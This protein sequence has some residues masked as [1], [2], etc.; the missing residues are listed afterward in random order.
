[1]SV[2][3]NGAQLTFDSPLDNKRGLSH[4]GDPETSRAAAVANEPRT[5]S[6]KRRVL[7]AFVASG[8]RGLIAEEL[9]A[10]TGMPSGASGNSAAKRLSDLKRDGWIVATD[11]RRLTSNNVY[12][13]VHVATAEAKRA[14]A[15]AADGQA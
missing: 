7:I 11:R 1:M 15:E 12:A 5:G 6:Q 8:E 10:V 3:G 9:A 4:R 2:Q 14:L 13:V